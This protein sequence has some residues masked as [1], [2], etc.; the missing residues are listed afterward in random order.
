MAAQAC[1]A[2]EGASQVTRNHLRM[3]A[4]LALQHRRP[5]MA[6]SSQEVWNDQDREALDQLLASE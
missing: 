2:L 4:P 6:Q 1:A 5:Q 3:V